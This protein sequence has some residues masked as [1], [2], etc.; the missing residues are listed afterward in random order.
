MPPCQAIDAAAADRYHAIDA[1]AAAERYHAIDAAA[2]AE[3]YQAIDAAA[4]E[5]HPAI[6]GVR[7]ARWPAARP[8][9]GGRGDGHTRR[10]GRGAGGGAWGREGMWG[11]R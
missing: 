7:S 2:A 3:R 4:A 8:H 11:A 1:A 6:D 10:W 9:C 5:R